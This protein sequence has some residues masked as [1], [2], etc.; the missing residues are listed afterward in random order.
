[1]DEQKPRRRRRQIQIEQK[2]REDF[3][4]NNAQCEEMERE[5]INQSTPKTPS[6]KVFRI[7]V[8]LIVAIV[9]ITLL[10]IWS[11]W[12]Q[13]CDNQPIFSSVDEMKERIQGIYVFNN[14]TRRSSNISYTQVDG[15]NIEYVILHPNKKYLDKIIEFKISS[16]DYTRGIINAT[17][18]AKSDSSDFLSVGDPAQFYVRKNAEYISWGGESGANRRRSDAERVD[19]WTPSPICTPSPTPRPPET[20]V[21]ALEVSNLNSSRSGDYLYITG[22]IRNTG[23]K[24]YK[25][26]ELRVELLDKDGSVIDTDWTYGVGSEGIR[27]NEQKK[28][29][30]IVRYSSDIARYKV[31]IMD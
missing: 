28:F 17:I 25:Y 18:T 21:K 8:F 5:G 13:Y 19:N 20:M 31:Y 10:V 11:K 26:V 9:S 16:L 4:Q 24:T 14:S 22:S 1:M 6:K 7:I 12:L 23:M 2:V 30:I 15:D 29:Q 3:E 27:P